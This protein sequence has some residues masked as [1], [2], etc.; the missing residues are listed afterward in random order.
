[1]CMEA[2]ARGARLGG[3]ARAGRRGGVTPPLTEWETSS[4]MSLAGPGPRLVMVMGKTWLPGV[5]AGGAGMDGA[6][7]LGCVTCRRGRRMRAVAV[8][9]ALLLASLDSKQAPPGSATAVA[10][11]LLAGRKARTMKVAVTVPPGIR[12]KPGPPRQ[13]T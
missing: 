4:E 12:K 8:L 10:V 13:A 9:V 1:M 5:R 11:T 3:R 6:N 7:G 2:G